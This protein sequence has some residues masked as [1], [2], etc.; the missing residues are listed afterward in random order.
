MTSIRKRNLLSLILFT[1]FFLCRLLLYF[2]SNS[3]GLIL[4]N[5][6][7]Y[8]FVDYGVILSPLI[9][10]FDVKMIRTI[11]Y[12]FV[13]ILLAANT[14]SLINTSINT[15]RILINSKQRTDDVIIQIVNEGVGSEIYVYKRKYLIFSELKDIMY[16][17][18][19]V[20]FNT[21]MKVGWVNN[22][23]LSITYKDNEQ[24]VEKIIEFN[25]IEKRYINV[26]N[27]IKGTWK[28]LNG[29]ELIVKNDDVIYKKDG[30][31]Y[32][33]SPDYCDDQNNYSTILYG[34]YSKP[35]ITIVKD[36]K[37]D[38]FIRRVS[39]QDTKWTE[40]KSA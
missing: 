21:K 19:E 35:S 24:T 4:I 38:I 23:L 29:N 33:Y 11:V 39:L 1:V 15:E 3:K 31:E 13:A 32:E 12:I 36:G 9:F 2:L 34:N 17:E 5:P 25:C 37:G 22:N 20:A 8:S 40:Y 27:S 14:V 6:I 16:N 28:S 30:K 7:L 26:L 10:S 18:G